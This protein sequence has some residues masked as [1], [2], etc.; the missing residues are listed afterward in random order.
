MKAKY[1]KYLM[2]TLTLIA[3]IGIAFFAYRTMNTSFYG[4]NEVKC[5]FTSKYILGCAAVGG[6]ITGSEFAGSSPNE[7][8][9]F[10]IDNPATIYLYQFPKFADVMKDDSNLGAFFMANSV[11]K[12]A[13]QSWWYNG[14]DMAK[15]CA[16]IQT[17]D[18]WV[19]VCPTK[20]TYADKWK[21]SL[22]IN[23]VWGGYDCSGFQSVYADPKDTYAENSFDFYSVPATNF[24]NTY[25]SNQIIT[26][27]GNIQ[28]SIDNP[29]KTQP[30]ITYGQ[31]N[32]VSGIC[33]VRAPYVDITQF[34]RS[35]AIINSIEITLN[36]NS[37]CNVDN[38]CGSGENYQNCPLDCVMNV[39]NPA[40]PTN[41]TTNTSTTN[42]TLPG[43]TNNTSTNETTSYWKTI[44]PTVYG[45][46][47]FVAALILILLISYF[48][49]RK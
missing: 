44:P 8:I 49:R 40:I 25:F 23:M 10:Q 33:K 13:D 42:P 21:N 3:L 9:D 45:L 47:I 16:P 29:T 35:H 20:Y 48:R 27:E 4:L 12:R 30:F 37:A 17:R 7:L 34:P 26:V 11:C 22:G 43:S 31:C 6:S 38:V 15:A 28:D 18:G 2:Y 14:D 39:S 24:I 1:E 5:S 32:L 46:F 36:I 19:G 41:P